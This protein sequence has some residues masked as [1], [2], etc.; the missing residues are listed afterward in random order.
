MRGSLEAAAL[1]P[2]DVVVVVGAGG[3]IGSYAVQLA[4]LQGAHVIGVTSK[5]QARERRCIAAGVDDRSNTIGDAHSHL[6][7]GSL[8]VGHVVIRTGL[9]ESIE[10][11]SAHEIPLD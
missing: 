2:K 3:G 8:W 9:T 10:R 6:A 7:L 5:A 1:E 11:E 4:A